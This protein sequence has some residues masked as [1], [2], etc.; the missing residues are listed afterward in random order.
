MKPRGS[1]KV[2]VRNTAAIGIFTSRYVALN[3]PR[4]PVTLPVRKGWWSDRSSACLRTSICPCMTAH[5]C[6]RV[7]PAD[8]LKP[9]ATALSLCSRSVR[10]RWESGRRECRA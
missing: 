5:R 9:T 4:R 8:L 10:A 3:T 1:E 2:R 6:S 7:A